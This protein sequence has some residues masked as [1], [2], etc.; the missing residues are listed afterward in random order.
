M[1]IIIYHL[2]RLEKK[3]CFKMCWWGTLNCN[4]SILFQR[5]WSDSEYSSSLFF[6]TQQGK[7]PSYTHLFPVTTIANSRTWKEA[8]SPTGQTTN[9]Q[10]ICF[11]ATQPQWKVFFTYLRSL[12]MSRWSC[13]FIMPCHLVCLC[14]GTAWCAL[15]RSRP[16]YSHPT[17]LVWF[18]VR[19]ALS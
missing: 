14:A 16:V 18:P 8:A 13:I 19:K 5:N 2:Q 17:H 12:I 11:L 9:F 6:H 4:C 1:K 15:W 10:P 7:H 3:K